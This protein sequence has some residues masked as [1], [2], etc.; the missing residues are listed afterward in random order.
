MGASSSQPVIRGALSSQPVIRGA[1][2]SQQVIRGAS[3]L[4]QVL[5]LMDLEPLPDDLLRVILSFLPPRDLIM[6]CRLVSRRWK[7][8]VDSPTL[9]RIKCER[10]RKAE[11]L[12]AAH[13]YPRINWQR[14]CLKE[15]LSRNLIRNP[16]GEDGLTHWDFVNGGDGWVVEDNHGILQGAGSQTCFV[17][18]FF[19]CQ[20]T[21]IIDLLKEGL[22][23]GFLDLHQPEICIS[24]W[25]AG[26]QDCGCIYEI[27]VQLLARDRVTVITE[28]TQR[29]EP[30]PQWN[31]STYKQVCHVFRTYGRG[32][33]FVRFTHRG[34][35]T[36]FWKG[37]YGARITNSSVTIKCNRTHAFRSESQTMIRSSFD[38]RHRLHFHSSD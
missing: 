20:K 2:S 16:C 10:E 21:Q 31:D 5:F 30:I 19:W 12:Q 11:I 32:V 34:K 28:F 36:Q 25:Y 6:R 27:Q 4:R 24:D 29:P 26:R 37:N 8:L 7:G 9:W 1:S 23:E 22:D 3:W 33:H 17:T 15:P 13:V 18:S 14:F 38:R 35:D